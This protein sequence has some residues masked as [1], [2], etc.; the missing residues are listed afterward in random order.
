MEFIEKYK[1]KPWDWI[2]HGME[3]LTNN[4]DP[5]IRVCEHCYN[6]DFR[7]GSNYTLCGNYNHYGKSIRESEL[8]AFKIWARTY[9]LE[10]EKNNIPEQTKISR[11]H[12]ALLLV[13]KWPEYRKD[14]YFD[15]KEK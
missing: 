11:R 14:Y 3:F 8:E 4:N 2:P 6:Q 10:L 12:F 5:M 9:F 7:P 15:I 13:K 1:D